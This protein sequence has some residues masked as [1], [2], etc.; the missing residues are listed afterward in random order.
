[1][2]NDAFYKLWEKFDVHILTSTPWHNQ[3]APS[4]K[5]NWIHK[6]FGIGKDSPTYKK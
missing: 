3:S 1:M 5:T 2:K 4:D 6:Y